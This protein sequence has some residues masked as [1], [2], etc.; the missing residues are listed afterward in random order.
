MQMFITIKN[1]TGLHYQNRCC[2]NT[3]K[4]ERALTDMTNHCG[5]YV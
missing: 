4:Y 5:S 2:E 1:V 3:E